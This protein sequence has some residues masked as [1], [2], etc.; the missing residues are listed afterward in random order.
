MLKL[1]ISSIR[2]Q[3]S[4]F[5]L[6][7]VAVILGV[8]FMAGTLV[9]TDTIRKSNDDL[10]VGTYEETDAVVQSAQSVTDDQGKQAR[11]TVDAAVSDRVAAVPGV[12]SAAAQVFGIAIVVGKDGEL[13]ENSPD[14]PVPIALAWQADDRLNPMTLV[15]GHAP[16]ANEIVI[17]VASADKG[18]FAVGE[19]VTVLDKAGVQQFTLAGI[20]TFAGTDDAAGAQVVAFA[21]ETASVV[22]GE[23]GRY[24]AVQ[25]VAAPDVSQSE[26]VANIEAAIGSPDIEVLTGAEAIEQA[27]DAAGTSM[28]FLNTF[29]MTFA[30][31][32]ILVGSFVIY[33]TFSITVAQRTRDTALLRAIGANRKQVMR[34][35][36]LE[37]VLVGLFGSAIGVALGIA[38]A[39]GIAAV[40]T[41]VDIEL[42]STAI[43]VNPST[44]QTA[45]IVGTLVTVFA[46]YMP[47]RRMGKVA[48]I[49]ALRDVAIDRTGTSKRRAVIGTLMTVGGAALVGSG[50]SGDEFDPVLQGSLLVFVG[51]A[52]LGPVIAR[53]FVA[54]VGA[55][56]RLRGMAGTLA[57]QN[58]ARSPR[59]TSA[60]ASALMVGVGLA[61]LMTV[62][63]A[64]TKSSMGKSIDTTV[65]SDWIVETTWG[66]GGLSPEAAARIDALAET[67]SVSPL[68]FTPA[69]IDGSSTPLMA[70]DPANQQGID[71]QPV[72][73][74]LV[75]L[76]PTGIA[77][78]QS[79]ADGSKLA[80][81]D[82]L[83][84]TFP[85]TG[86][87]S[88]TVEAIFAEQ[89]PS[90]GYVIS[91][92][93]YEANVADVVDNYL[94][95][96]TTPGV[97]ATDARAAIESVLDDYPNAS[98]KTQEE[99]KGTL[100]GRIDKMLNLIYVLLFMVLTIAL[101]G[102]ANTLALS[103]FERTREIGLLR[104][105]GMSRKQL[106]QSVRWESVMI[107]L[108]GTTLGGAIGFGFAWALVESLKEQGI[109]T[110][111]IPA[112]Q[113]GGVVVVAAVASVVAA[114]LPARRAS[115]LDVL[116]A[117]GR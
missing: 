95:V 117:I 66:M 59:R 50:L 34:S 101:F 75:N 44:I 46:A 83:T 13:L 40:F 11:G 12:E 24:D 15:E 100:A 105:V 107:A 89:G 67:A 10:V 4:R 37:S 98:V 39:R 108:L 53:P 43:V 94:A 76:S 91:L 62:L 68:R 48:P 45:M 54:L 8:A 21:P 74:D 25:V 35:V 71:L 38:T 41:I 7:S 86:D 55:P 26:V 60:T 20:A 102:I 19:T 82:Q 63:A 61:V 14:R 1:T 56:L 78:W 57:R 77:V 49:A 52:M 29:L 3:K 18:G 116:D 36:K 27:R 103:V 85:E 111:T 9:L 16:A 32:A 47:A 33:N 88:L 58:A 2:A 84:V 31:V 109:D 96:N 97:S 17:D 80:V 81:G 6:T 30:L 65:R 90:N 22:L 99:F 69:E 28:A 93:A 110:L 114:A 115:R 73:G 72:A 113:L 70:F 79:S 5:F 92:A 87:Q 104:A 106:R 51:V 64:S 112:T 23:P 42:P